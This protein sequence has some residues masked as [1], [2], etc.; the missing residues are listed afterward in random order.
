MKRGS[1]IYSWGRSLR[2]V[3]LKLFKKLRT[4]E[5]RFSLTPWLSISSS[6]PSRGL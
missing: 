3:D 6:P 2:L 4:V 1:V 5:G